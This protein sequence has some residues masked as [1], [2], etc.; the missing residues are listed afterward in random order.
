MVCAKAHI[1]SEY[2][3]FVKGDN[4]WFSGWF[5]LASGMPYTIVDIK[6]SWIQDTPGLRLVLESGEPQFELK[7]ADK[8]RSRQSVEPRAKFPVGR[9]VPVRIHLTL[10]DQEDGM[11]ELWLDGRQLIKTTGRNLPLADTVYNHFEVGITATHGDAVV[12]VDDVEVSGTEL[13]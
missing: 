10:S 4:Y 13:P 7:W 1:E 8:P 5:F 3:H 12:F 2:L 11:N 9:W 6:S